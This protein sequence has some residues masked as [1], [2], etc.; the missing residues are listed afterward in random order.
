MK[1]VI[2]SFKVCIKFE[3]KNGFTTV[4][5]GVSCYTGLPTK[6]DTSKATLQNLYL[7]LTTYN[8]KKNFFAQSINRPEND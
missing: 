7:W 2:C 5:G 4:N 8:L 3:F 1:G 6:D